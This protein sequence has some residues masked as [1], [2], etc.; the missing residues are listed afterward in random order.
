MNFRPMLIWLAMAAAALGASYWGLDLRL[1]AA[2]CVGIAIV[3]GTRTKPITTTSPDP[4][5]EDVLVHGR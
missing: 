2:G 1:V 4:K 5:N 3:T